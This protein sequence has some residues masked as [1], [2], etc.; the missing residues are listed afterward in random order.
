[1]NVPIPAPSIVLEFVIVGVVVRLL[2]QTPREVTVAPLSFVTFPPLIAV[3]WVINE[4]TVVA[5]TTG[6]VAAVVVK[7]LTSP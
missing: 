7:N 5:E 1:M 4:P 3:V 2:Q 6:I